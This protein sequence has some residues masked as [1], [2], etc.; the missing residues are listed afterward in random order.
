MMKHRIV[1]AGCG[2]MSN[3]WID[4]ASKRDNTEIVG[5][6]DVNI[7]AAKAMAKRKGLR[8]P[9][10]N[11]LSQAIFETKAN[12]VFDVTIPSAH[13]EIV[14]TAIKAG[15]HVFG[16]KPMAE[17]MEDARDV[18]QY[19]QYYGKNYTVMQNRRYLK[20]IRAFQNLLVNNAIGTV[21]SV[22]ADFF[23]GPHFGGFRDVMDNPLILDMA[24][25]TFDQA[26]LIIGSDPVSVYCHEYNPPGSWYKGN[27]SAMCIFEMSNGIV[28]TYRGSW[29]A[30]GLNTSWE[31]DWRVTGSK[32]SI[33]WDGINL[34]ICEVIDESQPKDF[35]SK[36]KSIEVPFKW[37]GQEGHWGCFDEMFSSLEENRMAE[38]DCRDNIKSMSMVF[39]AIESGK[40]M[41][42]II[43]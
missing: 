13:K 39:G 42:K 14:T 15:C 20:K 22:H 33:R 12:L 8:V 35:I 26:R 11:D 5:F 41:K 19:A 38:T 34:P 10:Y 17:S 40:K 43:L 18:L 6:V 7:D 29:C 21:G 25:H 24:I 16:E 37:E 4:Y 28:F 27:A 30:E 1:V 9:A 36:V 31:A 23:L 32:G 2:E 3:T